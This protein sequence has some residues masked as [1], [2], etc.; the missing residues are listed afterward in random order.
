ML[1]I[2][3]LNP[4]NIKALASVLSGGGANLSVPTAGF[5]RISVNISTLQY[6]ITAGRMGFV[7]GAT[8]A[9]WNPPGVFPNF[10]LGNSA[11]N[12]FYFSK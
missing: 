7:G 5:Y 9:G 4:V 8:G 1:P 3:A 11:T 2:I 12:L 6:N 10:A